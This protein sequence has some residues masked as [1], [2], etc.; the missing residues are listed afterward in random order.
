MEGMNQMVATSG[1]EAITSRL[2]VALELDQTQL[3]GNDRRF[4]TNVLGW[5]AP[6][7]RAEMAK[8]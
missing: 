7:G 8:E 4:Q 1:S 3:L 2:D 5:L 6:R